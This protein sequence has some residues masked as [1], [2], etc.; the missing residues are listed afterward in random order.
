RTELEHQQHRWEIAL[1]SAGQGVWE[2]D[3]ETGEVHHSPTWRRLRGMEPDYDPRDSHEAWQARLHPD[4]VAR[5]A[6]LVRSQEAGVVGRM[7][8]EY[9]ERHVSGDYIWISSFGAPVEWYPDGRARRVIGTDTDITERKH[10]EERMA[11][12]S[13]R[14]EL[15]L[16]VSRVGVFEVDLTSGRIFWDDRV[17]EMYGRAR[18]D[19][20]IGP[21]DWDDMLHPDDAEMA[22]KSVQ[23]AVE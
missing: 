1:E 20:E 5:V 2:S 23:H 22:Q 14:L 13:R 8:F 21:T 19:S 17:R 7:S 11:Q 18:D 9:R 10:A 16:K 4:D 12:L 3:V 6:E 15:A